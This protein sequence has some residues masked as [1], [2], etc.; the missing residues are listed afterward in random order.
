MENFGVFPVCMGGKLSEYLMGMKNFEIY[1]K[2]EL[3]YPKSYLKTRLLVKKEHLKLKYHI[4]N[5]CLKILKKLKGVLLKN[6]QLKG[7][8]I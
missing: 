7:K 4:K 1:D 5:L 3:T 8:I 6:L 2:K